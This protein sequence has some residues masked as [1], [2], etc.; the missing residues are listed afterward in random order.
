MILTDKVMSDILEDLVI[1]VDTRE[2][3]NEHIIKFFKDNGIKYEISKL[4][5][6]DY[7]FR[8][9]HFPELGCDRKVL[10]EKKNSL[11]EIAGNF[12]KD[13]ARFT[14]EFERVTDE[15][16]HLV[17]ENATWKKVSNKSWRSAFTSQSMMA[18]LMTYSIRF[19]LKT[20][21]VPIDESPK[22]IYNIIR[23]ELFEQLKKRRSLS[24]DIW[25]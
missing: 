9:P 6:A 24:I 1:I 20:W 18:S 2:Q 4:D 13:R 19:N 3:K 12:T 21:F 16:V 22:L 10:V 8:L 14:R 25:V 17:I 7:S 11:D 5:T 23:Y 15:H